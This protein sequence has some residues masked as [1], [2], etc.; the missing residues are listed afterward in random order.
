MLTRRVTHCQCHIDWVR[1]CSGMDWRIYL[2]FLQLQH[3]SAFECSGRQTQ[4]QQDVRSSPPCSSQSDTRPS[5]R[6]RSGQEL[7]WAIQTCALILGKSHTFLHLRK[8]AWAKGH[9]A[10]RDQIS[11]V[12]F[13]CDVAASVSP[14]AAAAAVRFGPYVDA[15][16]S[17]SV[18]A[19]IIRVYPD[20]AASLCL[21]S[22]YCWVSFRPSSFVIFFVARDIRF[23]LGLCI[24][25]A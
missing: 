20:V 15:S 10:R 4:A 21:L 9:T 14:A 23:L 11:W 2:V 24:R 12:W 25:A 16:F 6:R 7:H 18:A 5:K 22:Q 3:R 13:S 19:A 17:L 1:L 8:Q